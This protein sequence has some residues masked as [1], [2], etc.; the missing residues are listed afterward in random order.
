MLDRIEEYT[1]N[2]ESSEYKQSIIDSYNKYISYSELPQ[3]FS[4]A[5]LENNVIPTKFKKVMNNIYDAVNNHISFTV[6]VRDFIV[7]SRFSSLLL[8]SY[9]INSYKQDT[10]LKTIIYVDTNL[11]L[12]DY[13]K[14][15]NISQDIGDKSQLS[16][17]MDLLENKIYTAEYVIWNRF[18]MITSNYDEAKLYNIL[19]ERYRKGLGNLYFTINSS[20]QLSEEMYTLMNS[21]HT[22]DCSLDVLKFKEEGS[23]LQW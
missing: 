14:A 5:S 10:T 7:S 3:I 2:I 9:F 19:L 21:T 23:I 18:S 6:K 16:H 4:V 11:L 17:S 12:D 15:M 13:K 20:R 8:D 22:Q 1:S